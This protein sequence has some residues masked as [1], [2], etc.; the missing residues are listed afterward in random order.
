MIRKKIESGYMERV[1]GSSQR[2][3]GDEGKPRRGLVPRP[4]ALIV[5]IKKYKPLQKG[6]CSNA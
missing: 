1:D 2:G 3:S 4:H 5:Y 6:L